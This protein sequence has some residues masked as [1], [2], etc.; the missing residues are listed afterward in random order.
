MGILIPVEF[1]RGSPGNLDSR[2]LSRETLSRWTG[3]TVTIITGQL[4]WFGCI[5]MAVTVDARWLELL[6]SRLMIRTAALYLI[7]SFCFD[8]HTY[9]SIYRTSIYSIYVYI[10]IYSG[11]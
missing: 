8:I 1:D 11:I 4:F 9:I 2:T 10:Y 3:R 6:A 5:A 7:V